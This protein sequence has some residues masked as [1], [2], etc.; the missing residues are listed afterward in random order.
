LKSNK[1]E[2]KTMA[3]YIGMRAGKRR[4]FSSEFEPTE[5][6]HGHIYKAIIGPFRTK[7]AAF[8]MAKPFNQF[9]TVGEAERQATKDRRNATR[10]ERE[11]VMRDCG[12]V[13]VR[14]ALGGIYWE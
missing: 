8:L 9:Q 4:V 6:S 12:L 13:K 14:G 1:G 3:I 11:Q 5:Q 7:A 10:R 2:N